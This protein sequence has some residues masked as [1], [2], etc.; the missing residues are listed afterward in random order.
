[1]TCQHRRC[2]TLDSF[3]A[4]DVADVVLALEL[5]GECAQTILAAGEQHHAPAFAGQ[6]AGDRL[7]DP[8]RG[9]GDDGYPVVIY[10]QTFT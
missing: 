2:N 1:M 8:A 7:A 9:T 10:R 3:P 5:R 6:R 4:A